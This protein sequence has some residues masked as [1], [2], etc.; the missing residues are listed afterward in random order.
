MTIDGGKHGL[1]D[2]NE[3]SGQTNKVHPKCSNLVLIV[4]IERNEVQSSTEKTILA[5][6]QNTPNTGIFIQLLKQG[7]EFLNHGSMQGI[8]APPVQPN[9][10]HL[11]FDDYI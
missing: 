10:S 5:L 2:G 11:V 9:M 6:Q 8:G 4:F 7:V 3:C 1:T